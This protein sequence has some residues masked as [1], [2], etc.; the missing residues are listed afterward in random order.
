MPADFH[1]WS[2]SGWVRGD[3][4]A[5]SSLSS[6]AVVDEMVARLATPGRFPNL[7]RIIVAGHSAGGQFTHRYAAANGQ[8]GINVAIPMRYVGANPSSY[9][10]VDGTRPHFDGSAGF[11]V[12]YAF[13]CTGNFLDPRCPG[14]RSA[15]LCPT[16]FN[17]W[18][19]GLD[20]LSGYASSMGSSALRTRL[21]ARQV[22]ILVGMLDNDPNHP[23]LDTSCEARLQGPHRLA[24][25]MNQTAYL[26]ARFASQHHTTLFQVDGAGHDSQAMFVAPP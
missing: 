24:R 19:Y 2:D 3:A 4:A 22:F 11:D 15:P 14:F 21:L 16:S 18:H 8:D 23:E 26:H 1:H 9:L 13:A 20:D 5:G 25:G 7:T 12:P 10:Y 6:Y 17:D